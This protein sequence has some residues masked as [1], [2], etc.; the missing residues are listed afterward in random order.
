MIKTPIY[1]EKWM[2]ELSLEEV[3]VLEAVYSKEKLYNIFKKFAMGEVERR[4]NII[5]NLP[6]GDPV[7][8]AIEKS[9]ARGGV[10]GIESLLLMVRAASAELDRREKKEEGGKK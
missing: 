3:Q 1:I 5:F 7:K 2:S 9:F 8:L 6:E 4:K 10:E